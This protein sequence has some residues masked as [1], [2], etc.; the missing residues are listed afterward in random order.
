ML[1]RT[2]GAEVIGLHVAQPP[3]GDGYFG[4]S[5][6][7]YE[8]D[9]NMPSEQALADFMGTGFIGAQLTPR[10]VLGC[11]WDQIITSAKQEHADLIVMSTHGRDSLRD[12]VI[13]SHTERVI[14]QAPC[15]VLVV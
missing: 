5:G 12:K 7:A 6:V 11:A 13:G 4:T 2:F 10:V 3:H 8:L 15:P 1:A 14:R 9:S